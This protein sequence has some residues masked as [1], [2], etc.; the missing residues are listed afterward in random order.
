MIII[1]M[2]EIA[3]ARP[4]AGTQLPTAVQLPTVTVR[5]AA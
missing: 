4:M 5:V 3:A 1:M 2:I